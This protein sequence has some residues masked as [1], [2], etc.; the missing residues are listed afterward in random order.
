MSNLFL[1]IKEKAIFR[2]SG[3]RRPLQ[4]ILARIVINRIREKKN[5]YEFAIM[6]HYRYGPF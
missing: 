2:M 5:K 1:L 4:L 3:Q 6:E